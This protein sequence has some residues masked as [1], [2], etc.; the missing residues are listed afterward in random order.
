[1]RKQLENLGLRAQPMRLF[2][3]WIFL[4]FTVSSAT[5]AQPLTPEQNLG[6]L[7]FFD[8]SLSNPPGQSCSSCHSPEAGF[9]SPRE[10]INV[11][12]SVVPGAVK[13]RAGF[14]KPPT[15]TYS[16]FCPPLSFNQ[17]R[18]TYKGGLFWD[19][20]EENL[21]EQAMQPFLNPLEMN[22]LDAYS[23]VKKVRRRPYAKLFP[24]VY[25]AG[26]LDQGTPED[27]L[28]LIARSLAAFESST[29]V[30]PFSSKYDAY[31]AGKA[32]LDAS[33]LRGLTLFAGQAN[34]AA[35]HPH[36]PNADGSAPLF[37]RFSYEN[38][39]APRNPLNPFY[40]MPPL[41]NPDGAAFID[42]GL[43]GNRQDATQLGKFKIPTLRNVDKRPRPGFIKAY[44]HNGAFK[45][46]GE[47]V[48]FYNARDLGG[49]PPPE[50]PLTVNR[51]QLGNLGLTRTDEADLVS[52]LKT[53]SDGYDDDRGDGNERG[54]QE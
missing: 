14:R 35:C 13:Q 1:M 36:H 42:L 20:R 19:G 53:L 39:G 15:V 49:F 10:S 41:I 31:L 2:P 6:Q 8:D 21:T 48:H 3:V 11:A 30:N 32:Q 25:G 38:I 24:S 5:L 33:E 9:T 17:A 37:T 46:L 18:G 52:F 34:C 54:G 44:M 22:N 27:S 29:R 47:V 26:A 23:V 40:K 4:Q 7:I 28:L 51:R 43:G 16:T 50:Y 12:G 45:S